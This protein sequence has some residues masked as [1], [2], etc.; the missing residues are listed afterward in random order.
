[1]LHHTPV[2]NAKRVIRDASQTERKLA[3]TASPLTHKRISTNVTEQIL[4]PLNV[5]SANQVT[6][7]APHRS[8]HAAAVLQLQ[9]FTAATM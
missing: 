4:K 1:M 8:K 7:V 3:R 6:K 2:T 9:I 5:I